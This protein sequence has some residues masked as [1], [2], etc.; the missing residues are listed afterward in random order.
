MEILDLYD[1]NGNLLNK[2]VVR[3]EHFDNGNIM[4]SI[5]F[6]KNSNGEF[7]IQKT[8]KNGTLKY[9]S[10]GGHVVHGEDG[11]TAIVREMYEEL[12][13]TINKDELIEVGTC[14]N[15]DKPCL[16]NI[17]LLNKNLDINDLTL[18]EEEVD[19]VLWLSKDKILQLIDDNK[20]LASHGYFFKKH[21]N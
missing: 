20:F 17:F 3:G 9:T 19:D 13:L 1:D 14:K 12:G 16:V 7:L 10:T 8:S 15:P 4:I 21:F 6:I 5:V 18:Q 2:T 11:V